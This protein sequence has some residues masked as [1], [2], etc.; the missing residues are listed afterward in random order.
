MNEYRHLEIKFK[1]KIKEHFNKAIPNF[2]NELSV[3]K[4]SNTEEDTKFSFDLIFEMNVKLSVRIRENKYKLW[5]DLTIRSK[6]K[7]Y[8]TELH[9]IID[10]KG[11]FY[12]YAYMTEDENNLEKIYICDVKTIRNLYKKNTYNKERY[13]GDGTALIGFNFKDI[14]E[15]SKKNNYLYYKSRKNK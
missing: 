10:G 11:Q 6:N 8:K 5:N 4:L 9:K 2:L 7:G 15:E 12:F 14:E 1:N 3:V 13:N